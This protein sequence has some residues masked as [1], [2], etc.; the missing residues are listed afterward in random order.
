MLAR[1]LEYCVMRFWVLFKPKGK[2]L[3]FVLAGNFPG[4]IQ[5]TD[6]DLSSMGQ[7]NINFSNISSVS[8]CFQCYSRL[9]PQMCTLASLGRRRCSLLS[10]HSLILYMLRSMYMHIKRVGLYSHT[11]LWDYSFDFPLFHDLTHM[12]QTPGGFQPDNWIFIFLLC[13]THL[14]TKLSNRRTG[15]S[16]AIPLCLRFRSENGSKTRHS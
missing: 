10:L 13:W 9:A 8:R 14:M 12:F 1:R 2:L 3:S 4:Y 11:M 15:K 5:G 6:S 16:T 7:S